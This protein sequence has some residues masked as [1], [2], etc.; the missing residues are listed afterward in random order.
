MEVC[1]MTTSYYC[2][3]HHVYVP[4]ERRTRQ[5]IIGKFDKKVG[6]VTR[7]QFSTDSSNPTI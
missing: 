1:F 7:S 6:Q 5:G 2:Y 4:F 3:H